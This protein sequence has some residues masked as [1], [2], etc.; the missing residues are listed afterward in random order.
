MWLKQCHKPPM[1]GNGSHTTYKNGDDWGMVY[2][3]VLTTW[4]A[5]TVLD[6]FLTFVLNVFFPEKINCRWENRVSFRH[7]FAPLYVECLAATLITWKKGFL[8][9]TIMIVKKRDNE[10]MDWWWK[11]VNLGNNHQYKNVIHHE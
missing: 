4:N 5:T 1:T 10:L 6:V 2:D 7:A 3:I 8:V 9:M 11:I